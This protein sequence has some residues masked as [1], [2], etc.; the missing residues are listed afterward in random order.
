M[1][2]SFH[3]LI[4]NANV[5]FL[6]PPHRLPRLQTKLGIFILL[7]VVALCLPAY[8][9]L[10]VSSTTY[11][12][13]YTDTRDVPKVIIMT[14]NVSHVQ[15]RQHSSVNV[16]NILR[17]QDIV[18][19]VPEVSQKESQ[20][21]YKVQVHEKTNVHK[22][23][24]NY[25]FMRQSKDGSPLPTDIQ[26]D[27]NCS[28]ELT[29]ADAK[30]KFAGMDAVVF[31]PKIN[32][33]RPNLPVDMNPNQAW[34]YASWET[35]RSDRVLGRIAGNNPFLVHA[36]W[37]YHRKSDIVTPYG[38]YRPGVAM[39]NT[40]KS[41]TEW[42]KGKTKLIIWMASNCDLTSWPRMG[43][44]KELNK[45]IPVDTYGKCGHLKCNQK[46][47]TKCK[48]DL[49]RPY[50]FYLALE[51][52]ECGDYITEK[53]WEKPLKHGVVPIVYGPNR[54]V[55]EEL[56]PP[57]SFI[58]IGDYKN[59]QELANYLKLL[60]SNPELYAKYL[61][62]QYKS[63]IGDSPLFPPNNTY[64][65]LIPFIE[66]VKRGELKRTPIRE[67]EY[68]KSCRKPNGRSLS[69]FGVGQWEPW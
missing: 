51:N 37:S 41:P 54:K 66:K 55:Y 65:I 29:L 61:E 14:N 6:S 38:Y 15:G 20:C 49:L 44:V 42:V 21:H 3:N 4:V 16:Q 28:I 19:V 45:H 8:F 62:W 46:E 58:Y 27:N 11:N 35:P 48:G 12:N 69:A 32:L 7:S 63:S 67:T 24:G 50:K 52:S 59:I 5:C 39:T 22:L 1:P 34:V 26:C 53:L 57:N 47:S 23:V 64:C 36:I 25:K 17:T 43:F 68:L 18:N 30:N 10:F 60:D 13:Y 40:T 31:R 56:A 2:F 33:P 9:L